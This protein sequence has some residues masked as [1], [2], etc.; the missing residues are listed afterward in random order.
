MVP[1]AETVCLMVPVETVTF[2]VV[3]A[4]GAAAA[5]DE[6]LRVT[7]HVVSTAAATR[8]TTKPIVSHRR[9]VQPR[10]H[11]RPASGSPT[12]VSGIGGSAAAEVEAG[13][14]GCGHD[15]SPVARPVQECPH[16]IAT[17]S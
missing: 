9:R 12:A 6:L 7:S 2:W 10:R 8:T 16:P 14:T 3:T 4:N 1:D 11:H 15:R 17:R 5:G 13:L